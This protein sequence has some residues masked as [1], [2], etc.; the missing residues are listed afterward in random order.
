M[1]ED[2]RAEDEV[3]TSA[4]RLRVWERWKLV[5]EPDDALA[6]S[7]EARVSPHGGRWFNGQD[8]IAQCC[9]GP[10]VSSRPCADIGDRRRGRRQKWEKAVMDVF[11]NDRFVTR[12]QLVSLIRV[13]TRDLGLRFATGGGAT[14]VSGDASSLLAA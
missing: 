9:E 4:E 2:G 3:E 1:H 7:L 13:M 12:S 11:K 6:G 8:V 14:T 5:V 10:R